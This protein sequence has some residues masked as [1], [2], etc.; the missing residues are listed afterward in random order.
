MKLPAVFIITALML[1]SSLSLYYADV[2]IDIDK[3]GL[4]SVSGLTNHPDLN[5][6]NTNAYTSKQGSTWTF[7]LTINEN[8]SNYV[9][10]VSLPGNAAVTYIKAPAGFRIEQGVSGIAVK[11]TGQN[12]FFQIVI[13]YQLIEDVYGSY[14]ILTVCGVIAFSLLFYFLKTRVKKSKKLDIKDYPER[15]RKILEIVSKKERT[16]LTELLK[17]MKIPKS[18]L[19]RNIDSLVRQGAITSERKGMSKIIKLKQ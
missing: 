11:G 12:Q 13:Q 14:I 16:T 2:S 1:S 17:E 3:S 10:S 6:K 5:V 7:N 4:V 9:Y 18:S 8:F 19:S 15:Q